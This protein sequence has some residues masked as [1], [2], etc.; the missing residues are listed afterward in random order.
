MARNHSKV[1]RSGNVVTTRVTKQVNSPPNHHSNNNS[2]SGNHNAKETNL[3]LN[4]D[5]KAK[6]NMNKKVNTNKNE[7]ITK[8]T[9]S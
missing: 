6:T 2:S 1:A 4:G 3:H 9:H 5:I 7:F 8:E